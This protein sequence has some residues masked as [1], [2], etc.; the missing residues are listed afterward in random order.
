VL[1]IEAVIEVAR[2]KKLLSE[3]FP[4]PMSLKNGASEEAGLVDWPRIHS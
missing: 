2:V 1:A 4:P 3:P